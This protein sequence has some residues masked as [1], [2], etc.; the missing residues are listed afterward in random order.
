MIQQNL[1]MPRPYA[2][3]LLY[4]HATNDWRDVMPLINIPTLVV[5]GKAS[6]VGWKSQEWMGTADP[7]RA[8]RDLRDERRRQSLHVH[9]E[10][11]EVQPHGAGI[12]RLRGLGGGCALW[13]PIRRMR[14][15]ICGPLWQRP[16]EEP[17][18]VEN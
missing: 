10:P 6:L 3:R 18:V 14:L 12:H 17:R 15:P 1:K 4:D 7:R 5:G 2:A 13:L 16:I 9:G 8:S 11:G